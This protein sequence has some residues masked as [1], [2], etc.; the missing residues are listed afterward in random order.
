M[1]LQYWHDQWKDQIDAARRMHHVEKENNSLLFSLVVFVAH[2]HSDTEDTIV[3]H[4]ASV[5]TK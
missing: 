4:L 3:T 5:E 2:H 1:A